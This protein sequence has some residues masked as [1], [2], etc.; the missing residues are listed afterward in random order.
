MLPIQKEQKVRSYKLKR[1]GLFSLVLDGS[2][3][4]FAARLAT[5]PQSKPDSTALITFRIS[6][7]SATAEG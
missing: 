3:T 5:K 4:I 1:A 2:G 7:A 6:L